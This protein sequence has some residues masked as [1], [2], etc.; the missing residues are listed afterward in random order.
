MIL[1]QVVP[2]ASKP[3]FVKDEIKFFVRKIPGILLPQ[4]LFGL[5]VQMLLER[6]LAFSKWS[7]Q[8][9]ICSIVWS[10][11]QTCFG[12][13][14]FEREFGIYLKVYKQYFILQPRRNPK[15]LS[16]LFGIDV[17]RIRDWVAMVGGTRKIERCNPPIPLDVVFKWK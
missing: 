2:L 14:C 17:V 6:T 3:K 10:H 11:S 12:K 13:D 8:I 5:N 1:Y 7:E 4:G 16:N 9:Q 15:Q